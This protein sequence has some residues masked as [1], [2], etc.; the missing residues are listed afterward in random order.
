MIYVYWYL[1]IGVAV[2]A[3]V[4]GAHRLT[5]EK[6]VQTQGLGQGRTGGVNNDRGRLRR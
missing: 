4:Y 6:E 2:L 5:K 1:G 3:V